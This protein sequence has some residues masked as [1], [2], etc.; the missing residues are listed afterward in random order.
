MRTRCN[1]LGQSINAAAKDFDEQALWLTTSSGELI[2]L[3]PATL[4]RKT[5]HQFARALVGIDI[6]AD[7]QHVLLVTDDDGVLLWDRKLSSVAREL[8]QEGV[9][10]NFGKFLKNNQRLHTVVCAVPK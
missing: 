9:R 4:G 6:S 10:I 2:T 7:G 1:D 8:K 5:V 3:E